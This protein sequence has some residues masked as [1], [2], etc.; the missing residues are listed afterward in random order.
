MEWK[1][2]VNKARFIKIRLVVLNRK[3]ERQGEIAN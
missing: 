2:D 3:G 1:V